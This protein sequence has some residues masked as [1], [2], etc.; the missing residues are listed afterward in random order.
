MGQ[1]VVK[2]DPKRMMYKHFKEQ[3]RIETSI[4]GVRPAPRVG[5]W[6]EYDTFELV[7]PS[8]NRT[9]ILID[10]NEAWFADMDNIRG[11]N[12][13]NMVRI[14]RGDA[15]QIVEKAQEI[16]IFNA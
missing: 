8:D 4:S 12:Y 11:G 6:A 1:N 7:T 15:M 5:G 3:K 13:L 2:T 14:P 10:A 16:G 9:M